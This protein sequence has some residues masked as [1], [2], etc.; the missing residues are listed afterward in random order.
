MYAKN[1]LIC[2]AFCMKLIVQSTLLEYTDSV[3]EYVERRFR[4]LEKLLRSFEEKGERVLRVEIARTTR[5]HRK[6]GVYYVEATLVL[7]RK[8]IRIEQYDENIRTAVDVVRKRLHVCVE[9]YKEK[10][11]DKRR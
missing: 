8:T 7:P 10:M 4:P 5:H 2:Y 3:R 9:Q 11:E 6:G 1:K